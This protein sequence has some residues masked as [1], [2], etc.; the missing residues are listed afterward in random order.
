[1]EP[2]RTPPSLEKDAYE[3]VV[4]LLR[5]AGCEV[6]RLSQSRASR[7]TPGIP[8]LWVFGP[9]NLYCWLEVKRPGG[10]L[11]PEQRKFQAHCEAR[12][13]EHVVGGVREVERLLIRWGLAVIEPSG[14]LVLTPHRE[15][16]VG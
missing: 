5:L 9:R 13:I 3:A 15:R 10:R 4:R 16:R 12:K 14:Q 2:A 7:Q 8:D 11:R 1:M 6:Y